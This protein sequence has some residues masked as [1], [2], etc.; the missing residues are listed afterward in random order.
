MR[1]L[2]LL[3][4]ELFRMF[5]CMPIKRMGECEEGSAKILIE[6]FKNSTG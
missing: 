3:W 5:L 1:R 6:T 2:V 4:M